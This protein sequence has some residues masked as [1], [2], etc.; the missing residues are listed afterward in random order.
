MYLQLIRSAAPRS[1][2]TEDPAKGHIWQLQ[3][4]SFNSNLVDFS[5]H[6]ST[7]HVT[8]LELR[9][10][11][12]VHGESQRCLKFLKWFPVWLPSAKP[13]MYYE[14]MYVH[15]HVLTWILK[16]HTLF[17]IH[18]MKIVTH[19]YGIFEMITTNFEQATEITYN[20]SIL[21]MYVPLKQQFS[22][23]WHQDQLLGHHFHHLTAKCF[24]MIQP[25]K[26]YS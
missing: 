17:Y 5:A 12:G 2:S 21:Y 7:K 10:K 4:I 22:F 8:S 6:N 3:I 11:T 19:K 14:R 16:T 18:Q 20:K 1:Q 24:K 9:G 26:L 25:H 15:V 23:S 13:C